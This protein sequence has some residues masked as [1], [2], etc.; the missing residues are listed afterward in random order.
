MWTRGPWGGLGVG[1]DLGI[2]IM[3]LAWPVGLR[4]ECPKGALVLSMY[5]S[6]KGGKRIANLWGALWR[7]PSSLACTLGPNSSFM[8]ISSGRYLKVAEDFMRYSVL[9]ERGQDQLPL[10]AHSEWIH[11]V[12]LRHQML[13]TGKIVFYWLR[14][15]SNALESDGE[16]LNKRRKNER[17]AG[18]G[19]GGPKER[20]ERRLRLKLLPPSFY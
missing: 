13:D 17:Q 14:S 3:S 16:M 15:S 9:A 11:W 8:P 12:T 5:W 2:K 18:W 19:R 10:F 1:E 7:G 4:S 20:E 6:S